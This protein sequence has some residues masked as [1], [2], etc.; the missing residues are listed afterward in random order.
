MIR[1]E[2]NPSR[3][4][5]AVFAIAWLVFFGFLGGTSWWKTGLLAQAGVLWA[6]AVVIPA[7]GLVW[8]GVLRMAF[9]GMSYATF[10]IGWGASHLLLALLYYAVLTPIGLF[11]R[12]AAD[13]PMGRR[14]DRSVETYWTPRD[15]EEGTK[16]YFKQF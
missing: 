16:R 14:F 12:F 2:R 8:P 15:T 6:V 7:A 4:Q 5:L 1:I 13:D 10:P 9:L 11:R 3:G